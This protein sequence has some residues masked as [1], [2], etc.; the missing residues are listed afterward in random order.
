[1]HS[2][3]YFK[4]KWVNAY[5]KLQGYNKLEDAINWTFLGSFMMC[6]SLFNCGIFS[7]KSKS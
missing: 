3:T 4:V 6:L 1:M 5:N 7:V 2:T